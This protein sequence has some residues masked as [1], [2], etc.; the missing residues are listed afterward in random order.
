[1]SLERVILSFVGKKWE[2]LLFLG[3]TRTLVLVPKVGSGTHCTEGNWY[4]YQKLG[5]DAP[6]LGVR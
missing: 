6:N 1:M 4:R 3:R 2:N 5:C